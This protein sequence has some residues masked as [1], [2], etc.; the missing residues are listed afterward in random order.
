MNTTPKKRNHGPMG[1]GPMMGVEKA[2]DFKGT[3]KNLYNYMIKYKWALI[4]VF[5][6]AIGSTIFS[7][8]GP[9]ILGNATTELFN[10]ITSKISGGPGI[11]FVKIGKILLFLLGLYVISAIFSY[12]QSFIMTGITQN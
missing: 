2:K 5:I 10:G 12:V 11:D 1:P 4:I 9:K 6:F 8:I 3:I 7:I